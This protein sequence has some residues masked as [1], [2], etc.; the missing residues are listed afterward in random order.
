M[1]KQRVLRLIGIVGTIACVVLYLL[2]PSFPTP[3]KL[4]V[5]GVFLGMAFSQAIEV[6]KRFF[7][8]VAILLVYESFRGIADDLNTKVDFTILPAADKLLFF[9]ELPTAWLQQYLWNGS[10]RWYDFALYI[11]YMLHFVLPLAL[12]VAVWKLMDQHYWRLITAYVVVSFAGFFTF[13]LFPASPPWMASD[14]GYI[15]PIYRISSDVWF[16]LGVHDFPSLYNEIAPNPVAAMPS[17]HAAYATL[18]AL[19]V[20]A[21]FKSR[22]RYVSMIYPAMI[23]FGTVYQGEH[24][25]IDELAGGLYAVGAFYVAPYILRLVQKQLHRLR[26]YIKTIKRKLA[27]EFS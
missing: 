17:L 21:L 1:T 15:E 10:V 23:Y 7:P 14:L 22:W 19:F 25:V 9:G 13:L 2:T 16:A 12:A 26:P 20:I 5:L 24:Y 18:F 6:L 8:F 4:L 11:P 3:D 27:R